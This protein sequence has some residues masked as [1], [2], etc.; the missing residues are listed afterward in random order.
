[1]AIVGGLDVPRRQITFDW[2]DSESG[3]FAGGG[4]RVTG[5]ASVPG[6]T[7]SSSGRRTLLSRDA[8]GGASW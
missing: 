4:S 2:L 6:W 3:R 1:M 7:N 5:S 8:L